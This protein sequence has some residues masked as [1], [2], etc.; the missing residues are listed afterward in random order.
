[1]VNSAEER[2]LTTEGADGHRKRASKFY[3]FIPSHLGHGSPRDGTLLATLATRR[4]FGVVAVAM[5]LL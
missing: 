4:F 5:V 2:A 3:L 1:M